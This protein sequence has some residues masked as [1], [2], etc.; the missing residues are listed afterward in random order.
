MTVF[1]GLFDVYTD[2]YTDVY[3]DV[4]T[5][6]LLGRFPRTFFQLGFLL[7]NDSGDR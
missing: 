2:V 6:Q 5:A 3:I 4:Y 7:G 1:D